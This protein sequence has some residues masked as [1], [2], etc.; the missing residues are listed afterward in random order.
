[1][2]YSQIHYKDRA[3]KHGASAL[4]NSFS[5]PANAFS[6][7]DSHGIISL[8]DGTQE[9]SLNVPE[10]HKSVVRLFM[11]YGKRSDERYGLASHV[12]TLREWQKLPGHVV[13]TPGIGTPKP[14]IRMRVI[15]D[16]DTGGL[17][18]KKK[19]NNKEAQEVSDDLAQCRETLIESLGPVI[20]KALEIQDNTFGQITS[21]CL[22]IVNWVKKEYG[23]LAKLIDDLSLLLDYCTAVAFRAH[24][25]RFAANRK[26]LEESN[27]DLP[28]YLY[29]KNFT[30]SCS[31]FPAI[32][33]LLSRHALRCAEAA[34]PADVLQSECEQYV[35]RILSRLTP[36][37]ILEM[38]EE[39]N[40]SSAKAFAA[41]P[42][43][44]HMSPRMAAALAA[45]PA[46]YRAEL[47]AAYDE[48]MDIDEP[49]H[50]AAASTAPNRTQGS[51]KIGGTAQSSPR[52][53]RNTAP[54]Q[55]ALPRRLYC[56]LH[57]YNHTH[58]GM[59][60]TKM[61][62]DTSFTLAMKRARSHDAP[63]LKRLKIEGSKTNISRK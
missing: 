19:A 7:S 55:N 37:Q 43:N 41:T 54:P 47:E 17:L 5:T 26:L 20:A 2:S 39:Q 32:I 29:V 23:T 62:D 33:K 44:A 57:G 42:K 58:H 61:Q 46:N 12:L 31:N 11:R 10:W 22:Q 21:T 15:D 28:E 24:S 59:T 40:A 45:I 51:G 1:M 48:D 6:A 27:N 8:D 35:Q 63:E 13:G 56:F 49:S 4:H 25:S 38:P 9:I 18:E 52:P 16:A 50:I 53:P 36:A 3:S 30:T 14:T 60:C 34:P